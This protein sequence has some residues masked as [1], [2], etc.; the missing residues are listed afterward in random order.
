MS[1]LFPVQSQTLTFEYTLTPSLLT[2]DAGLEVASKLEEMYVLANKYYII[3][4]YCR[5]DDNVQYI[6]QL[7]S[8]INVLRSLQYYCTE[9]VYFRKVLYGLDCKLLRE[10]TLK[11]PKSAKN[12]I[13][14]DVLKT[15]EHELKKDLEHVLNVCLS[16]V[17]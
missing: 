2:S 3:W 12:E 14:L 15:D 16:Y 4:S 9:D 11:L 1:T 17:N 13:P 6:M 5:F 8:K 10:L 7:K